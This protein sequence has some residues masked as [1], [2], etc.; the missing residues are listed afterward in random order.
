M[1]VTMLYYHTISKLIK[2]YGFTWKDVENIEDYKG[3]V[4][5]KG[6]K[7]MLEDIFYSTHM[8]GFNENGE[9][10]KILVKAFIEALKNKEV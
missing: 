9:Y 10:E 8:H 2:K 3:R 5:I 4:I 6:H 1:K 7:F